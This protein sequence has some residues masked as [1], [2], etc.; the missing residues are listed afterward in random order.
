MNWCSHPD[1][2]NHPCERDP[3]LRA[4]SGHSG[5]VR[6]FHLCFQSLIRRGGAP[7]GAAA[8]FAGGGMGVSTPIIIL[9]RSDFQRKTCLLRY[10]RPPYA[11]PAPLGGGGV[12][13]CLCIT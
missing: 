7:P 6:H 4:P 10:Y 9:K 8:T 12:V 13:Q 11:S 5:A 1:H 3:L 2:E